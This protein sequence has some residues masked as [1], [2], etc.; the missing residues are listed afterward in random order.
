[1][2][3]LNTDYYISSV[4]DSHLSIM[5]RN[6]VENKKLIFDFVE[7]LFNCILQGGKILWCGN[8][9]SAAESQ[10]MSAELMGRFNFDRGPIASLALTTDT[11]YI[12]AVGNDIDYS[13]IFARQIQGL[14]NKVDVLVLMSTSGNSRN[15][16]KAATTANSMGVLTLAMLGRDGG[17]VAELC[18]LKIIVDSS[19]TPRIQ[20]VH[21]FM[22]HIICDLLEQKLKTRMIKTQ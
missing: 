18:D 4:L 11:S 14:A 15:I 5:E 21:Q 1:M 20:E 2:A 3:E 13:E 12:T 22:G 8:G 10:H 17:Q 16:I 19:D 7:K 6:V 9:G